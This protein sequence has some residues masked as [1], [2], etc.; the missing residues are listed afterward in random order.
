[1]HLFVVLNARKNPAI[2]DDGVLAWM[3]E[4]S[5]NFAIDTLL[6]MNDLITA[7]SS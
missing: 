4:R 3:K 2:H 1:M 5:C 7:Y 6:Y